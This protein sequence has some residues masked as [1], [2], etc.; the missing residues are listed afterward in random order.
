MAPPSS[1]STSTSGSGPSEPVASSMPWSELAEV[2]PA[3]CKQDACW[4]DCDGSQGAPSA[5]RSVVGAGGCPRGSRRLPRVHRIGATGGD[6]RRHPA[7]S[8]RSLIPAGRV[9]PPAGL[10]GGH[11]RARRTRSGPAAARPL[12]TFGRPLL[13]LVTH[14]PYTALQSMFDATVPHGWH[15]YCIC[16]AETAWARRFI[17]GLEPHVAG[18]YLNFLDRDDRPHRH[19]VHADCL[20]TPG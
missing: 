13:D 4:R 1:T 9:A 3:A 20:S 15:Y 6:D 14:R 10:P 19:G 16:D 7:A 8:T 12:R 11:V 5:A 2:A 18:V 17:A